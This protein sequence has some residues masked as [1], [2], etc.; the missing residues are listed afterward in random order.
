MD[1]SRP[2]TRRTHLSTKLAKF[3][4]RAVPRVQ[5]DYREFAVGLGFRKYRS[6]N[7]RNVGQFG[8]A[9][10][11]PL[12]WRKAKSPFTRGVSV[13][14]NSAVPRSFLPRRRYTGPAPTSARNVPL[15]SAHP[16]PARVVPPLMNTG[17]GA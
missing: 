5:A 16:S 7:D 15:A 1:L 9:V 3:S 12:C 13:G 2:L 17:R 8:P 10:C 6:A 4:I 14:G 11:P